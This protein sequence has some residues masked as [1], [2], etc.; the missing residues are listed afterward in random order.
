MRMQI[1]IGVLDL[2][3]KKWILIQVMIISLRL[4]DF[5]ELQIICLLF[6]LIFMQKLDKPFRDQEIFISLFEKLIF[7]FWE[8]FFTVFGWY[9]SLGSG[10]VDPHIFA[11]PDPGS[12]NLADPDPKHW[13]KSD[14]QDWDHFW[15]LRKISDSTSP[16]LAF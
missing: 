16:I 6:S 15:Y 9:F 4:T 3:W 7:W 8:Y 10:S 13:F 11:T 5:F 1:R 14:F 12:Q 2:H